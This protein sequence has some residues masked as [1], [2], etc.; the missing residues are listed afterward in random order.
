MDRFK[1]ALE[2]CELHDLGFKGDVF[3][4]TNKQESGNT[5]IR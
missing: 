3:T 2:V 5:H 4:W 1:Q